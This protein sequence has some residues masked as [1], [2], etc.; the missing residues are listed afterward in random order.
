MKIEDL[1]EE[2]SDPIPV[3]TNTWIT[4]KFDVAETKNDPHGLGDLSKANN[5]AKLAMTMKTFNFADNTTMHGMRYIFMRNISQTRR[6][7]LLKSLIYSYSRLYSLF[8]FNIYVHPKL[9]IR[10][11]SI[12]DS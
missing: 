3:K 10:A 2:K 12:G 7:A 6:Y 11:D 1:E 8:F 4:D 9:K 5:F